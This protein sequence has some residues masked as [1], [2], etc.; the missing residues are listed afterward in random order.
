MYELFP[1]EFAAKITSDDWKVVDNDGLLKVEESFNNRHYITY[2]FPIIMN[3]RKLLAGYTIDVTESIQSE[4][5]LRK[6]KE[7]L[8]NLIGYANAP[9]IVWDM[10]YIITRFNRAFQQLTGI[11]ESEALGKSLSILFPDEQKDAIMD[12][13]RSS[14]GEKWETVDIPILNR[15]TGEIRTVLW[16]SAYI[17]GED[18]TTI[19]ATIAQGTDITER[20]RR[21]KN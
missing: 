20:K 2:K 13:I 12:M 3:N 21:R 19:E 18:D 15:K 5:E 14:S 8:E 6:T 16:N 4:N 17:Y 9:I 1:A 7:Y 10:Q 11:A